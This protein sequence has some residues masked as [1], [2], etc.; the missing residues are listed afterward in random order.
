M[1][2]G[3][4]SGSVLG[5]GFAARHVDAASRPQDLARDFWAR[6]A[7]LGGERQLIRGDY[8]EYVTGAS[9]T[10][11]GKDYAV[12]LEYVDMGA[13]EGKKYSFFLMDPDADPRGDWAD[14][15]TYAVTLGN[16]DAVGETQDYALRVHIPEGGSHQ[17][18]V[19]TLRSFQSFMKG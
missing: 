18:M 4:Y 10:V 8:A 1:R 3:D 15:V 6:I 11:G 16:G 9:G 12:A 17:D 7:A 5:M 14:A 19:D 2:P 13:E